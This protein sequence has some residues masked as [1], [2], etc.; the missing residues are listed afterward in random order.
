MQYFCLIFILICLVITISCTY[1]KATKGRAMSINA[2]EVS[3]N[4]L[5][6]ANQS[7][8]ISK[9]KRNCAIIRLNDYPSFISVHSYF[10]WP[11]ARGGITVIFAFA[12]S[13]PSHFSVS[14]EARFFSSSFSSLS[15]TSSKESWRSACLSSTLMINQ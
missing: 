4:T 6:I 10:S 13:S 12:R 11:S 7:Y 15:F 3:N 5:F 2:H 14:S 8:N 1:M 9:N